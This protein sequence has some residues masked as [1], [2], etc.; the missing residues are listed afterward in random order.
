M[1]LSGISYL[2]KQGFS[3]MWRNRMMG[4]ASYCVLTVSLLLVGFS[5]LFSM[6]INSIIGNIENQ[7]ELVVFIKD[8]VSKDSSDALYDKIAEISNVDDIYFYSSEEAF[9]SLKNSMPNY[10]Y[11]FESIE[12]SPLPDSY[13]VKIS[14]ISIIDD[15]VSQISDNEEVETIQAPYDFAN[16][17]TGVKR[18][19]SYIS[20][21]IIA[22]LILV[23]LIIISNTTR[24]AVFSRRKEINIMKY[25]GATNSFIRIP[26]FID[27]M[28]TGF[29]SGASASLVTWISYSSLTDV[30]MQ[31]MSLWTV[32]GTDGI[33]PFGSISTSVIISY[34]VAGS[35]IGAVGTVICIH[36]HLKV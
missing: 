22:A 32:I 4:F 10:Q 33:I 23:S 14:D 27:G 36:K 28:C 7:N 30:L 25:V 9:E 24:T 12:E 26:F 20:T 35:F 21:A 5:L 1:R 18:V 15:T 6:N 31:D 8:D 17:F 29:L 34:V 16:I 13:R 19:V 11:V 2:L 3:G